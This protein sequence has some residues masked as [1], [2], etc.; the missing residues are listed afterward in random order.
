MFFC[1]VMCSLFAYKDSIFTDIRVLQSGKIISRFVTTQLKYI[2]TDP[3]QQ[4]IPRRMIF[5]DKKTKKQKFFKDIL[6][7]WCM[8]V[9]KG[10]Q[11]RPTMH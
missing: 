1:I 11:S 7:V 9:E 3:E 6:R 2:N 4:P 8:G 10:L 5:L